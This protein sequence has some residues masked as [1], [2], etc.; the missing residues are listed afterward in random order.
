MKKIAQD[1]TK[2][3]NEVLPEKEIVALGLIIRKFEREQISYLQLKQLLKEQNVDLT[4]NLRDISSLKMTVEQYQE[5]KKR[6]EKEEFDPADFDGY[7]ISGEKYEN[8]L[9][10][11]DRQMI[12][13]LAKNG[14]ED[15][16][17]TRKILVQ[18]EEKHRFPSSNKKRK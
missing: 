15:A 14:D 10:R 7:L 18:W 3:Y 5:M 1:N 2:L 13:T 16:I 6:L 8:V 11:Y 4:P 17:R 12:E 9:I